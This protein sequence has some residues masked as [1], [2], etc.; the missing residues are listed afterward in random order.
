MPLL[1]SFLHGLERFSLTGQHMVVGVSGGAD[2]LCLLHLLHRAAASL[3]FTLTAATLDHALRG[4]DGAA[5]AAYVEQIAHNWRIPVRRGLRDVPALARLHQLG[6]EEAAR[7]ARYGFLAQVARGTGA[8]LIAVG[9]NADD[10]AET[11]LLNLIRGSGLAGLAGMS[12]ETPLSRQHLLPTESPPV[13]VR[14]I[15]PLLD[16]TREAIDA[17]NETHHLQPRVDATNA[18][19]HYRRNR[20][21]H[22]VLPILT[23][24]NPNLRQTLARTGRIL[25][26]DHQLLTQIVHAAFET[27]QRA[28]TSD[29]IALDLAAFRQPDLP[30]AVRRGL[31][32]EAVRRLA[33]NVH[34]IGLETTEQALDVALNGPTGHES[35][36]PSGIILAVSYDRI[37]L[38]QPEAGLLHAG[39][40]WLPA[41]SSYPVNY[42]G[43][44]PIPGTGWTLVIRWLSPDEDPADSRRQPLTVTLALPEKARLALRTRRR[45]DRVQPLGL[46]G[47]SQKLSDLLINARVPA[48]QRDHL[49]LL[50]VNDDIAWVVMGERQ[51]IGQSYAVEKPSERIVVACW[52]RYQ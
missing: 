24:L 20:L 43:A 3:S 51:R 36:L 32:R 16:V 9:H 41:D 8:S 12:P 19:T 23:E 42:P 15:R 21:R 49:P 2:S 17:Y 7:Q 46:A 26:A 33:P 48:A 39:Q 45:G 29:S 50:T 1:K 4:E 30:V 22:E 38:R 44:T 27:L 31:I 40:P 13:G 34:D 6:L 37:T 5:D 11:I 18:D 25:A 14:I 47:H 28:R 35:R 10:Q 52:R